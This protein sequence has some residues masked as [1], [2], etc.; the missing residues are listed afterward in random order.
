MPSPRGRI[1]VGGRIAGKGYIFAQGVD[2]DFV[3]VDA[4]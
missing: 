3:L 2:D 1:F 4:K